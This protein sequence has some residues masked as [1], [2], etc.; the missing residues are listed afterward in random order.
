MMTLACSTF[1]TIEV[2]AR[3]E[4]IQE[5]IYCNNRTMGRES[6]RLIT[7]TYALER[8]CEENCMSHHNVSRLDASIV[9]VI[10]S[11]IELRGWLAGLSWPWEK[12]T[13]EF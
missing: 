3:G 4:P 12:L 13:R 11:T 1:I 5:L 10:S 6:D 8:G 7:D 9:I 2:A